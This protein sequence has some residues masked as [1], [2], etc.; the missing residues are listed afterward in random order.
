MRKL[1]I[2]SPRFPPTNAA[3]MHRVRVSLGLYRRYGWEPTVLCIDPK[4][5]DCPDDPMLDRALPRDVRIVR[6][7]AWDE[8]K[9]RRFGFGQLGWRCLL[10]LYRAGTR[11]VREERYDVVFFSTTVFTSFLLG[12]LWKRRFGCKIVYDFQ[13]PWYSDVALYTR[14]NAPGGWWKYRIDQMLARYLEP[15]ALRAADH[16]ISVSEGYVAALTTRYR[17]LDRSKFTVLPFAAGAD[18]YRL[19][20]EHDVKHGI[21]AADQTS[22]RWV[23][24][25][26]A[27]PDMTPILNVLFSCVAALQERDAEFA[28][29]LRLDF[30]GT[31]YA[32]PDRTYKLVEPLARPFGVGDLVREQPLR[33]PYFEALSLYRT[34]DAIL[35]IGSVHA[36]YTLSKLFTCILAKKPTLALFHSRSLATKIAAKFPSVFV[37][38][39]DETPAEPRFRAKVAEG[40]EW[41][42]APRFDPDEIDVQ[43]APWSAETLTQSQCAIFDRIAV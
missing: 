12:R 41:L 31:N 3:D 2:V 42:R 43:M 39:F 16:I 36:D 1:L 18:D 14:E 9:C 35:L 32:P 17:W 38:A 19:S 6:I 4:T 29:R 13:D 22:V 25:G 21:F 15:H 34:S 20:A 8:K 26:R 37:A 23:S 10:P 24:A 33:V 11:L 27:G 40:I 28:G 5:S 7:R 30:V